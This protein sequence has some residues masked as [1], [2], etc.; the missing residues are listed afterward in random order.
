MIYGLR[1][2]EVYQTSY[3]L[4]AYIRTVGINTQVESGML[5]Y[6]PFSI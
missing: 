2:Y 4:V 3:V 1:L 5:A 6:K